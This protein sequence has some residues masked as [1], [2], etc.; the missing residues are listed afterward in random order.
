[1]RGSNSDGD[2]SPRGSPVNRSP[3]QRVDDGLSDESSQEDDFG[4]AIKAMQVAGSAAA[5]DSLLFQP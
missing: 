3:T 4:A 2:L 1:M 5:K